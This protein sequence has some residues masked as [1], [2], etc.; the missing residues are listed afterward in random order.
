M[1][2]GDIVILMDLK[3][4]RKASSFQW[5]VEVQVIDSGIGIDQER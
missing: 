1:D 3:N 4:K 2:K 5:E